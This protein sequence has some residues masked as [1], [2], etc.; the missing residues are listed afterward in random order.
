MRL[1]RIEASPTPLVRV[2]APGLPAGSAVLA[3]LEGLNPGLS[4]KDR[5]AR[6]MLENLFR[7]G[8]VH[9]I[10]GVVEASSGNMAVSLALAA[11]RLGLPLWLFVPESAGEPRLERMMRLGARV[12]VTPAS[13]GTQGAQRRALERASASGDL[14]YLGQHENSGNP[15]AHYRWTGP[16]I[17][18]QS[19]G[20]LQGFAAGIGT[21]G[22]LLGVSRFLRERSSG[23][24]VA[25]AAPSDPS[26]ILGLRP[27]DPES[28]VHHR[29]LELQEV[30]TVDPDMAGWWQRTVSRSIGFPVGPSSG[31]AMEAAVRLAGETCG[32]VATVFP[33]HG[34]NYM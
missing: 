10:A 6:R 31:A 3:K 25:G 34:F 8:F 4:V 16:E 5:P 20:E 32:T 2:E 30:Y 17:W 23:I 28:V 14:Y 15:E 26:G 1:S 22:T 21:G 27:L 24:A 18:M 9:R 29:A 7:S 12:T 33:D 19:G 13:E 11:G